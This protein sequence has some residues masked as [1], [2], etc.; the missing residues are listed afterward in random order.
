MRNL[1]SCEK[2]S[3]EDLKELYNYHLADVDEIND[4]KDRFEMNGE[5]INK[6]NSDIRTA[7]QKIEI[8][9]GNLILLQNSA[10][11]PGLKK[12]LDF[13]K[14]VE[15]QKYLHGDD[16]EVNFDDD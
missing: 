14:Y 4:L 11:K 13:S 15:R 16:Y 10:G 2:L 5:E 9:Q 7:M 6:I 1:I 12:I 3:K 8:F